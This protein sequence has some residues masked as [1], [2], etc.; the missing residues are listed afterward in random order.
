MAGDRRSQP[1]SSYSKLTLKDRGRVE[2]AEKMAGHSSI[3]TRA[4]AIVG[5]DEIW[6]YAL[7]GELQSEGY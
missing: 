2:G 7:P 4:Y 6:L 1:L 5:G 3:G